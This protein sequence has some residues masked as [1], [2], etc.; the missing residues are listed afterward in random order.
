MNES[1]KRTKT[2]AG[3]GSPQTKKTKENRKPNKKNSA[4]EIE[5]DFFL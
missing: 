5:K 4:K 2:P 3:F 1:E